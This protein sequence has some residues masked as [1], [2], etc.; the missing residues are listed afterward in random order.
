MKET[1]EEILAGMMFWSLN[2]RVKEGYIWEDGVLEEPEVYLKIFWLHKT[3]FIKEAVTLL[4]DIQEPSYMFLNDKITKLI[5]EDSTFE[6]LPLDKKECHEQELFIFAWILMLSDK[7]YRIDSILP[8]LGKSE[9]SILEPSSDLLYQSI[10]KCDYTSIS[11]RGQLNNQLQKHH[12]DHS[13]LISSVLLMETSTEKEQRK[14]LL[15]EIVSKINPKPLFFWLKAK[16]MLMDGKIEQLKI[17]LREK[18]E[19]LG[20]YLMFRLY[21]LIALSRG[22]LARNEWKERIVNL[23]TLSIDKEQ[24]ITSFVIFVIRVGICCLG[25]ESDYFGF[26]TEK[27]TLARKTSPDD[28]ALIQLEIDIMI[29]TDQF[30][31]GLELCQLLSVMSEDGGF[32]M[33]RSAIC[34]FML[35]DKSSCSGMLDFYCELKEESDGTDFLFLLLRSITESDL[36][37]EERNSTYQKFVDALTQSPSDPLF[38]KLICNRDWPLFCTLIKALD[39]C[40]DPIILLEKNIDT[41]D[42]IDLTFLRKLSK[43]LLIVIELFPMSDQFPLPLSRLLESNG[44]LERA[45]LILEDAKGRFSESKAIVVEQLRVEILR[46]QSDSL[47]LERVEELMKRSLSDDLSLD[48]NP[49]YLSIS[50]YIAKEHKDYNQAIEITKKI[51]LI[52][53]KEHSWLYIQNRT[54]SAVLSHFLGNSEEAQ[55]QLDQCLMELED[56]NKEILISLANVERYRYDRRYKEAVEILR[57]ISNDS[58]FY[59]IAQKRL[60]NIYLSDLDQKQ[61]FLVCYKNITRRKPSVVSLTELAKACEKAGELEEAA[62]VYERLFEQFNE[63]EFAL[64][65]VRCL[66]KSFQFMKALDKTKMALSYFPDSDQIFLEMAEINFKLRKFS[67]VDPKQIL[68][69]IV[70]SIDDAT[71]NSISVLKKN[72]SAVDLKIRLDREMAKNN[73]KPLD[74]QKEL[75]L[76]KKAIKTTKAIYQKSRKEGFSARDTHHILSN[77]YILKYYTEKNLHIESQKWIISLEKACSSDQSSIKA[78]VLLG[79]ELKERGE[80]EEAKKKA[81]IALKIDYKNYS[82][83]SLLSDCLLL[84][85]QLES[86]LKGF[87]KIHERERSQNNT[88]TV[89]PILFFY[90]RGL[91]RLGEGLYQFKSHSSQFDKKILENSSFSIFT[92]GLYN[93]SARNFNQA[94]KCL[95]PTLK[96]PVLSEYSCYLLIEIY[97]H[98]NSHNIYSNYFQ[99]EKSALPSEDF[100]ELAEQLALMIQ[101]EALQSRKNVYLIF[102]RALR[103]GGNWEEAVRELS[104]LSSLHSHSS[105]LS[106]ILYFM[107]TLKLVFK[108]KE[109]LREDFNRMSSLLFRPENGLDEYFFRCHLLCADAL[110]AKSKTEAARSSINNVLSVNRSYLQAHEYIILLKEQNR[111]P[112][113]KELKQAYMISGQADPNIAMKYAKTLISEHRY[114]ESYSIGRDTLQKNPWFKELEK[115]VIEPSKI[116]LLDIY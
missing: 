66:R 108:E 85:G 37:E 100:L 80:L 38:H 18:R 72:R 52:I 99:K 8:L 62:S 67:E 104:T 25:C 110:M 40:Q 54:N 29:L 95:S 93:Y 23:I 87:L 47:G 45:I 60:A 36:R 4:Q 84:G 106:M 1:V 64:S 65:L 88:L 61:S 103:K 116:K 49:I 114:I 11:R 70:H 58:K 81:K 41:T 112:V 56:P 69:K 63:P 51:D 78:L 32:S 97:L 71:D 28:I 50:A 79:S 55:D 90:Y 73:T 9:R 68:E 76:I 19:V 24:G 15:Q 48:S 107:V 34:H 5:D 39:I 109:G 35:R 91:G 86:G 115:E 98:P 16:S 42:S 111:E 101:G 92:Q 74:Y 102:I 43:I 82:A 21:E 31:Q 57:N 113:L 3:G 53:G 27:M 13:S 33:L 75:C 26:V 44:E 6:D 89:L 12:S 105:S 22:E 59:Q 77:Y 96:D 83:L 7:S 94:I 2:G 46:A 30:S 14:H 20:R 17:F 10:S